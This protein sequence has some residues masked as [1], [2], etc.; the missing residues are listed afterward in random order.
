MT[1]TEIKDYFKNGYQFE[2]ITTISA[3]TFR[4][5]VKWGYIPMDSQCKIE[6]FTNGKL[7]AN[8]ND[9]KGE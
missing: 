4:N 5:W 1:I 3:N 2:K 7:K 9:A 8:Y 6:R